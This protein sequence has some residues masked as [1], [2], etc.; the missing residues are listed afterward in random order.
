MK[1]FLKFNIRRLNAFSAPPSCPLFV[2]QGAV[3]LSHI[4]FVNS[5]ASNSCEIQ[6]R[7]RTRSSITQGFFEVTKI[8][9]SEASNR[10]NKNL[11]CCI[12]SASVILY[13]IIALSRNFW[14]ACC[15]FVRIYCLRSNCSPQYYLSVKAWLLPLTSWMQKGN[16]ECYFHFNSLPQQSLKGRLSLIFLIWQFYKHKIFF[17]NGLRKKPKRG[18]VLKESKVFFL[19]P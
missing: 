8:I 5:R 14:F 18:N 10:P 6:C 11:K 12:N 13:N 19:H 4:C 17:N 9:E 16:V 7:E 2:C 1:I 3:S 15:L